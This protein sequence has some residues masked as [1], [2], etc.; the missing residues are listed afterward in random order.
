MQLKNYKKYS[1]R[2]EKQIAKDTGGKRHI[3][4]GSLWWKR[5]D[6]ND[7]LFQYEDKFTMKKYYRIQLSDLQKIEKIAILNYK[8]PILR[9]GFVINKTEDNYAVLRKKDCVATIIPCK[10]IHTEYN[11]IKVL[12]E[13]LQ[14]IQ[15][16]LQ[17]EL[18]NTAYYITTWS[19]FLQN[20]KKIFLL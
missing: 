5:G 15:D 10:R 12:Q 7:E 14:K 9:F 17:I 19:N 2:R 1:T 4:S 13:D 8:I 11:S 18:G 6:A 20:R 16:I 3:F